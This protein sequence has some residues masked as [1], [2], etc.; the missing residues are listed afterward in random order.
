[1]RSRFK[2]VLTALAVVVLAAAVLVPVAGAGGM[3][4]TPSPSPSSIMMATP[5]PSPAPGTTGA[6]WCAGGV[7]NG[8][9]A[10]GGTGMWGTGSDMSWLTNNPDALAAWLQ[11]KADHLAAMQTWYDTDKAGLTSPEAQQALH[12][13]WTKTWNDM[14]ALYLQYGDGAAWTAPSAGMWGGWDM[15]GMMGQHDWDAAHMWGT[16]H[17]AAWM[18]SH[19]GALGHWLTMRAR[20]TAAATAWQHRYGADPRTGAAQTAMQTMRAHQRTQV[21]SFY[22]HHHL[23]VTS[24]RMRDGA[25]GWMGLGGMWGGFGW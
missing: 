16:G 22:Q 5:A 18:G 12:D 17:G 8:T 19:P 11:L 15:G 23:T 2:A 14:K 4:G 6:G 9:G 7:W 1:M 24:S 3:M 25:G 21:K 10:W 20:Q 13:L